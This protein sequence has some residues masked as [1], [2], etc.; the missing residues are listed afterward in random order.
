[1]FEFL[2]YALV[3]IVFCEVALLFFA[4][5]RYAVQAVMAIATVCLLFALW[6]WVETPWQIF[7]E[8]KAASSL[9]G[10][11]IVAAPV[12]VLSVLALCLSKL[13]Q[14]IWR[15]LGVLVLGPGVVYVYPW[16]VLSSVCASGLDCV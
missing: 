7:S 16:F 15:H 6:I 10:I 8:R 3:A 12:A 1:M 5:K 2:I 9:L 14:P 4:E 13:R 11:W